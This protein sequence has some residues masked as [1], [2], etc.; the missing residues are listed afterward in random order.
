MEVGTARL[1]LSASLLLG[2]LCNPVWA[3]TNTDIPQKIAQALK[4]YGAVAVTRI[5]AVPR[6]ET[7]CRASIASRGGAVAGG[8]CSTVTVYDQTPQHPMEILT[9]SNIRV[10][11]STP[12]TFGQQ[13]QTQLIDQLLVKE[14]LVQNC[15]AT[16]QNSAQVTLTDTFQRSTSVQVTKSVTT[17][18]NFSINFGLSLTKAFKIGGTLTSGRSETEGTSNTVGSSDTVTNTSTATVTLPKQT[19]EVAILQMY[20]TQFVVPFTATVTVE[21][22]LSQN[23]AGKTLLSQLLDANARTFDIAGTI[24]AIDA[25]D[26]STTFADVA[27]D[28]AKCPANSTGVVVVTPFKPDTPLTPKTAPGK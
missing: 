16:L 28:P 19:A 25:S 13:A 20:P 1:S 5:V 18:A 14:A 12:L 27:F 3:Q 7:H 15:S 23:D 11:N 22:D 2:F 4:E 9:A 6:Q 17:T 10:V 26:S 24:Q 8:L 21:A